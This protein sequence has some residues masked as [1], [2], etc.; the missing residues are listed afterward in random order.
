[1]WVYIVGRTEHRIWNYLLNSN[2]LM[3][4]LRKLKQNFAHMKK[5]NISW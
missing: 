5:P 4:N 1:M 3:D 2:I